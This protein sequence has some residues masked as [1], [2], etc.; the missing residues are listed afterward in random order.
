MGR[1]K[2]SKGKTKS[3]PKAGKKWKT[4]KKKGKSKPEPEPPVISDEEESESSLPDE[5]EDDFPEDDLDDFPEDL[6]DF[7]DD[8]ELPDDFDEL[9]DLEE[10]ELPGL[11]EEM[12]KEEEERDKDEPEEEED[13]EPGVFQELYDRVFGETWPMWVGAVLLA[14]LSIGLFLI[15]SPWGAS[16]GIWNIGMNLYDLMGIPFDETAGDGVMLVQDNRYSMLIILTLVGAW[17]SA[18]ISKDFALRISSG[19]EMA[20]GLIGGILMGVG[21]VLAVGCTIGSFY[22]AIPALSA[23]ALCFGAGLV[24]GVYLAVRY[25]VWEI[26]AYPKLSSGKSWTFLEPKEGTNWQI[27]AGVVV[28]VLGAAISLLFDWDTERA[29]VGFLLIGLLIGVIL[30]RS[31]FCIY[32]A[33]REPFMTCDPGPSEAVIIGL[34]VA[35]FGFTVIKWMDIR[36]AAYMIEPTFFVPGLMGGIIFGF[37]MGIA[38]GC[39]VGSVWRAGEGRT[40]FW[41][42]LL[43]MMATAPLFGE[44]VY[45][46][47]MDILPTW[48]KQEVFLPDYFTY[49]GSVVILLLIFLLWYYII[50]WNARTGRLSAL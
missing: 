44:F 34:I 4:G 21:F 33:L 19:P 31:R 38:G 41:L 43:G 26:E 24:I 10:D 20:K 5:A 18:L 25:S 23:G 11:D 3:K 42:A 13:D 9:E 40:R 37:G 17:G 28:L 8:L 16:N 45:P 14:V 6:D 27:V 12:E 49:P 36:S 1:K 48:A 7:P 39:T 35:T 15:K 50:N 32:K 47:F 46:H 29:I 22:S 2:S 30:Q